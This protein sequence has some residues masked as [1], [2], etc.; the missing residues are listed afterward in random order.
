MK[1]FP[2]R[3]EAFSDPASGR[4]DEQIVREIYS[5]VRPLSSIPQESPIGRVDKAPA[6][7]QK[8]GWMDQGGGCRGRGGGAKRIVLAEIGKATEGHAR[9]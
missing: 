7:A 9:A 8:L 1:R 3:E 2:G 5:V 4:R 6:E